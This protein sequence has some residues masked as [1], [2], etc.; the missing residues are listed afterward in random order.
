DRLARHPAPE[1]AL[2]VEH[3]ERPVV[4]Q[5]LRGGVGHDEALLEMP[6]VVR[7]QA[8]PVAVVAGEVGVDQVGGD[9]VGLGR[10]AAAAGDDGGGQPAKTVGGYAH[11]DLLAGDGY[12]GSLPA[13]PAR[14]KRERRPTPAGAARGYSPPAR[15]ASSRAT[16]WWRSASGGR[17]RAP[18]RGGPAG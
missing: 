10:L 8:H 17:G 6:H 1:S 11:R 7:D 12:P 14:I 9:Q 13:R 2:A 16:R 3:E 15:A 4:L 5:H 18:P